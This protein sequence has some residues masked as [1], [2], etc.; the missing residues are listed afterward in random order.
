MSQAQVAVAPPTAAAKPK[1]SRK[2]M[3]AHPKFIE[4]VKE[5]IGMLKERNGSSRQAICK[6]ILV[7]HPSVNPNTMNSHVRNALKKGIESGVLARPAR[8]S[9]TG[10]TG[11]FK[12][13]VVTKPAK[14]P[15]R[16]KAAK[17]PMKK[18]PVK[19]AVPKKTAKPK[20]KSPRKI[21]KNA[22][23]KKKLGGKKTVKPK[24]LTGSPKKRV[25]SAANKTKK[26]A[27]KPKAKK[28]PTKKA[29]KK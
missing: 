19:K 4:M 8:S 22:A 5:A 14:K 3:A 12:L 11:R 7:K 1:R 15:M 29:A 28:T 16:K 10:A 13:G 23:A 6:A 24:A 27:K 2:A 21:K 26:V 17:K 20:Q 18:R 9:A 25:K